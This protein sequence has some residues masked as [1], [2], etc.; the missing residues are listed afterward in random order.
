MLVEVKIKIGGIFSRVKPSR[1][2]EPEDGFVAICAELVDGILSG[3]FELPEERTHDKYWDCGRGGAGHETRI[4]EAFAVDY[5]GMFGIGQG[6][7][8]FD[9]GDVGLFEAGRK[10]EE[11]FVVIYAV[12]IERCKI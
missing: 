10:I 4:S 11:G 5:G 2:I 8:S 12:E 7:N 1:S 3:V 9:E 6:A